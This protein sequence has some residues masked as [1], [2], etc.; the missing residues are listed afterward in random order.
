MYKILERNGIFLV[1]KM[2]QKKKYF[3][4]KPQEVFQCTWKGLYSP[5]HF[6]TLK[7][8]RNFVKKITKPDTYH[9]L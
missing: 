6:K 7:D 1:G 4:S 2:V 9:D 5:A 3:W 8:A